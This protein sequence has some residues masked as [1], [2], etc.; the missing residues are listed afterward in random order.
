MEI[1]TK[2]TT[3]GDGLAREDAA[4]REQASETMWYVIAVLWRRR[5]FVA[6]VTAAAT[7]IAVIIALLLPKWYAAEARVLRSEGGMSLLSMA[8]RA[9]GGLSRLLGG[10]GGDY[11]RYLADYSAVYPTSPA[12]IR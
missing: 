1:Q 8:D 2:E 4:R 9:T 12:G 11:V 7:V 10:G 5:R 3:H 6:G